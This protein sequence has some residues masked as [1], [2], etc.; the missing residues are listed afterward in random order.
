MDD[1]IWRLE[2]SKSLGEIENEMDNNRESHGH[3][4]KSL[5]GIQSLLNNLPCEERSL[6]IESLK[7][8]FSKPYLIG[9]VVIALIPIMLLFWKVQDIKAGFV[10]EAE[11]IHETQKILK[12]FINKNGYLIKH[13]D[14]LKTNKE[15]GN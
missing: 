12:Q 5:Q 4:Q 15:G 13:E 2:V 8:K 10:K 9:I 6:E 1:E 3:M 11:A 14:D 7:A